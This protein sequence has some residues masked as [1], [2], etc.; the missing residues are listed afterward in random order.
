MARSKLEAQ[1]DIAIKQLY[2]RERIREDWAIKV[3]P[4]KTLYVDRIIP[5]ARVAIE[6]DGRQHEEFV[7]WMHTDA[8]GFRSHQERDRVKAAWLKANGY[9]LVRVNYD[10][11]ISAALLREKILAALTAEEE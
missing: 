7:Q 5:G 4:G 8:A 6:A 3:G 10:E 9:T 2:P 11:T 1:L